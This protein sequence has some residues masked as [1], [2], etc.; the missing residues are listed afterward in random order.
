MTH[1]FED[2]LSRPHTSWTDRTAKAPLASQHG[3]TT[4]D[5]P[6]GRYR[7]YGTTPSDDLDACNVSWWLTSD[8]PQGQE[9]QYRFLLRVGYIGDTTL[10][11]FLSDCILHIEGRNLSDLR[12]KLA[13]QKATMIQAFNPNLWPPPAESEPLIH[14][15]SIL[16]P[17]EKSHDRSVGN[18]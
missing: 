17:G 6:D 2:F 5:A 11:L 8:V 1:E 4:D 16:Y 7:A 3:P 18:I 15:I 12:N 10:H 13:R 14:S 9:F